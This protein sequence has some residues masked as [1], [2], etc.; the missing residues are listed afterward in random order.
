[1]SPVFL[2][3]LG[4]MCVVFYILEKKK[5]FTTILKLFSAYF[6]Q[7][8]F[9]HF[10]NH[11]KLL[12]EWGAQHFQRRSD[13]GGGP[14]GQRRCHGPCGRR[15]PSRANQRQSGSS[16]TWR[17]TQEWDH[18]AQDSTSTEKTPPA[19]PHSGPLLARDAPSKFSGR[20]SLTEMCCV[21]E[22]FWKWQM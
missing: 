18:G 12:W 14:G 10:S 8:F 11:H 19:A 5:K 17:L 9:P 7:I 6:N 1:M 4:K 2:C 16:T 21:L 3:W 22:E 20:Y 13:K 15:P